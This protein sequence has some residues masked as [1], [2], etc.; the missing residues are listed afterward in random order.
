MQPGPYRLYT[1]QHIVLYI[2]LAPVAVEIVVRDTYDEIVAKCLG[3]FQKVDMALVQKVV[4]AVGDYFF[5]VK[6]QKLLIGPS[7]LREE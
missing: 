5:I 2:Q 1:L 4:C 6:T 3:S 7:G